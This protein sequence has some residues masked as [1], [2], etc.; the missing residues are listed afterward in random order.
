MSALIDRITLFIACAY[1]WLRLQQPC[2]FNSNDSELRLYASSRCSTYPRYSAQL[3]KTRQAKLK[4]CSSA[5]QQVTTNK[6]LAACLRIP[7]KAFNGKLF[8]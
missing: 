1:L 7:S 8:R 4:M 6:K 3:N 5:Q 2:F